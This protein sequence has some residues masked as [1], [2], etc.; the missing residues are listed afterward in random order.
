MEIENDYTIQKS[1]YLS[2]SGSYGQPATPN[3]SLPLL[4]EINRNYENDMKLDIDLLRTSLLEKKVNYDSLAG[5]VFGSLQRQEY[6]NLRHRANVMQE[7]IKL[8]HRHLDDIDH[9]HLQI[10]EM[11]FGVKL[12]KT[13]DTLKRQ[14]TL[15]GQLL[16]LE[17]QRREEE[18]GFWKDT[19]ELREKLFEGASDYTANRQRYDMF[20]EVEQPDG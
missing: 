3:E 11:L 14:S 9:R 10:Q 16:Q 1:E 4:I 17:S 13:P 12:H 6:D 18:L 8:H 7:R 15:E 5:Q 19:V 2:S 20:S